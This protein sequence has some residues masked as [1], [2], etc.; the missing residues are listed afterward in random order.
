VER[1][2]GSAARLQEL[3]VDNGAQVDRIATVSVSALDNMEKLR[4]Q[5]P[6]IANAA[7]DVTN[8]IAGAGRTAHLELE[9]LVA[10]FQRLNEFGVASERQ[11]D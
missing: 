4:G 8:N 2:T 6:V 1:I 9:S 10:G 3:V 7:K 5:L 11:V